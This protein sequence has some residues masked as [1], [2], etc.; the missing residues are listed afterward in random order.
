MR[1]G[2][3]ET[4]IRGFCAAGFEPVRAAFAENFAAGLENGAAFA[5]TLEGET[6]VHLQGGWADKARTKPWDAR[7]IV[8]VFST[9]KP[10]A[11]LVIARLVDQGFLDYERP[12]S[13]VWPEFAANGK[14]AITLG[15]AM[16]HQAGLAAF[17]EPIDPGLWFQPEAL[18]A[19]F[20]ALAPLWEPGTAS[21]YHA[22]TFSPLTAEPARRA[23]PRGRTLGV[24]LAEDI[25]APFDVDFR[26]G[27]AL[28]EI[29][30]I[31]ELK[32]PSAEGD[33]GEMTDLKRAVF[34]TRWSATRPE[35]PQWREAE[36]PA[37]NG[38]GTAEAV[39]ALYSIYANRGKLRGEEILS[40]ATYDALTRVRI[41]GPELVLPFDV[42]WCAGIMRNNRGA[43]GPNPN[44]LGH[45]G[46][47]GSVGMADPDHRLSAAYV[48][49][50]MSPALVGDARWR[51][52]VDAL[53]ESL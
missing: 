17:V 29:D 13:E 30:R 11:A 48:M 45:G 25:C 7:T 38:H 10:I 46:R 43:L 18:A 37:A 28:S 24:Q 33:L 19:H 44:A 40:P 15:Q 34:L 21:G 6:V 36:H 52:L 1:R 8:P 20:A 32:L 14:A 31:A 23:D 35:T 49:N 51:R 26:I 3:N 42:H 41:A 27:H 39:A 53:Y 50:K 12:L 9:T 16:S 5:V 22:M 4:E 2:V 47:G